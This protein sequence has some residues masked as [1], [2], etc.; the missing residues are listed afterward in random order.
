VSTE[1][2]LFHFLGGAWS[3]L[4]SA[5]SGVTAFWGP[6][7]DSVWLVGQGAVAHFD[8]HGLRTAAIAGTLRAIQGRTDSEV[9]LGGDAGLFRVRLLEP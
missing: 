8:G 6:R 1:R 2:E 4:P 5:V 7:A 9:W 3:A